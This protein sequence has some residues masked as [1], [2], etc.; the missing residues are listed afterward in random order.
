MIFKC[1]VTGML[2]IVVAGTVAAQDVSDDLIDRRVAA[3][4]R[5]FAELAKTP[6]VEFQQLKEI[7]DRAVEGIVFSDLSPGQLAK[8]INAGL[9]M[10]QKELDA[11]T[12]RIKQFDADLSEDG[13]IAA[14]LD[15]NLKTRQLAHGGE[16]NEADSLKRATKKMLDHPKLIA[17]IRKNGSVPVF[18]TLRAINSPDLWKEHRESL[19][20]LST[21]F[22]EGDVPRQQLS[23]MRTY[24]DILSATGQKSDKEIQEVRVQLVD[25]GRKAIERYSAKATTT[26]DL[27]VDRL[28]TDLRRQVEYLESPLARGSL[29]GSP[30]KELD[31]VWSSSKAIESWD[32][33]TG[34]LVVLEFWTTSCRPCVVNL[35]KLRKLHKSLDDKSI[36]MVGVTNQQG[37]VPLRRGI[38]SCPDDL[39]LESKLMVEYLSESEINWPVVM[40]RQSVYNVDYGVRSIP[41]LV[42]VDKA[43]VIRATVNPATASVEEMMATIQEVADH[44][45]KRESKSK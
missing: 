8:L 9:V 21:L 12:R 10:D 15:L 22:L 43:G 4:K 14:V 19:L 27:L 6:V 38:E 35:P 20:A 45:K 24:F 2:S 30:A 39:K 33:L 34:N 13:A 37:F 40:T 16:R 29:V 11:A 26:N 25:A 41:H 7:I 44:Q 5:Q 32:D 3:Y 23:E 1:L 17:A 28:V 36:T 42:V 31:I 18:T